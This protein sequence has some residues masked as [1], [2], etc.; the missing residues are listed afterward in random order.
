MTKL[1]LAD[2]IDSL[3]DRIEEF[4]NLFKK[5]QELFPRHCKELNSDNN[6]R[7]VEIVG[8]WLFIFCLV[9]YQLL[10]VIFL[11]AFHP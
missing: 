10:W 6:E 8:R 2:D 1:R 4:V 11:K 9:A 5:M 7:N 3:L